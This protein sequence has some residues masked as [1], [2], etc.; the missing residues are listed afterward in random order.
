[1]DNI[2]QDARPAFT[3]RIHTDF[4]VWTCTG[5]WSIVRLMFQDADL[6]YDPNDDIP[7]LEALLS[8]AGDDGYRSRYMKGA[9]RGALRNLI[10]VKRTTQSWRACLGGRS[11]SVVALICTGRYLTD[12]V[13]ALKLFRRDLLVSLDLR[14]SGFEL[15]PEISTKVLAR[16]GRIVEAPTRCKPRSRMEG[17]KIGARDWCT[18]VRTFSRYRNG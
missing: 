16:G 1:M 10:A 15:D 13:T 17:N 3:P 14:A 7:M 9:D 2:R 8:G 11:L 4:G 5:T 12:T 6:E 18:A